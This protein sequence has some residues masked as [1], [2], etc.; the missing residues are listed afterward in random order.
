MK[1]ELLDNASE[2]NPSSIKRSCLPKICTIIL[3]LVF[4]F[5]YILVILPKIREEISKQYRYPKP[6][7][8]KPKNHEAAIKSPLPL[9][10]CNAE[11]K[12]GPL[13]K[14]GSFRTYVIGSYMDHRYEPRQITSVAIAYRFEDVPYHCMMCCDG[15]NISSTRAMHSIH[16]DHYN[17]DYG[18]ADI[19]CE[20]S[21]DC[22]S[23]T[24]VAITSSDQAGSITSF[25]PIG[26][27]VIPKSYP[28]TFTVCI[29]VMYNY[30]K[31]LNLIQAMEMFKLLGVQRV[32]IYKSSCDSDTQ[33]VLD[34]Y[35]KMG[36]VELIPWTV[37][38]YIK[39]S[40][41]WQKDKSPG[42]LHYH[43]QVPA[44]NDCV[45]RY[46][47]QSHYVALQDL[48]ELILPLNV[49]TWTELLL[50]L[51]K[52]HGTEVG[53]EFENNVFPF[54]AKA[55]MNYEQKSW[56]SI[57]GTNVLK[58][59]D[60]I[61]VNPYVFNNIKVIVNPRLVLEATVHGLLKTVNGH[62]TVRVNHDI[63]RLY[64]SKDIEYPSDTHLIRD[65]RL[66]EYAEDLIPAVSKV[67]QD[68]GFI[69][70]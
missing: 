39:V 16:S 12:N 31:V 47:Y 32:A 50:E 6:V 24:H 13:I 23:P 33:K 58:Y 66:W 26:N 60:R 49:R 35:V 8:P 1:Y 37:E 65:E 29:S 19:T 20:F 61:P 68:C 21:P 51:E 63:A 55:Q 42:E 41:G 45:H 48:D 14:V 59:V 18:T 52:M 64:H 11:V 57:E 46:M 54:T 28:F 17:F 4:I 5:M 67:L 7:G 53:F 56:N 25:Q 9:K 10:V 15:G 30:S 43:G 40:M 22:S 69:K 62:S 3:V 36:F 70:T 27:L 44:L 2:S 38:D 34:Y